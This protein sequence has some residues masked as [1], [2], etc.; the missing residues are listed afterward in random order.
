[1]NRTAIIS[2]LGDYFMKKGKVL[3]IKEYK[4][5]KDVPMR[6]LQVKRLFNSWS[7]MEQLVNKAFPEIGTIVP[8][9]KAAPKKV[10]KKV[11]EDE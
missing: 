1:M 4:A 11:V 3:S 5:E 7:R 9:V 10:A 8:E 6:L 2:K